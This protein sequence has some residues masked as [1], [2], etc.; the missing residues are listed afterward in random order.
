[1]RSHA[2]KWSWKAAVQQLCHAAL[3]CVA[4]PPADL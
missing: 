2:A 3:S 4:F 1:V